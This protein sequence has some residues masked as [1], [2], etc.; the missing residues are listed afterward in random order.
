[1]KSNGRYEY[2]ALLLAA[3]AMIVIVAST[4]LRAETGTCGGVTV[5]LPFNDVMGNAFFCQIAEAYFSGLTNGT[6]ATTY[7]PSD[8]VTREQMAAFITRTLDQSLKRGSRR[9]ALNQFWVPG[10]FPAE[11]RIFIG[12]KPRMV[13]SDGADL[14]VANEFEDTVMRVRASDGK[15]L[16]TWTGAES[17]FGILVAQNRVYVTADRNPGRL[18]E[19]NPSQPAG[20]VTVVTNDLGDGTQG[21]AFDGSFIWTTAPQDGSVSKIANNGNVTTYTTGFNQPKGILYDGANI[22]VTDAG[23]HK[24]KKLNSDG[25]VAQTVSVGTSPRFPIFDGTNIWVPSFIN[26]IKVVRA[27]TGTVLATLTGNGL[28]A[29][30]SAAFDGERILVVNFAGDSVSLWRASDLTP[31]GTVNTGFATEPWGA[32]SDGINF[33]ITLSATDRLVRF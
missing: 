22:W 29:P 27:S 21:I 31:L 32:C 11:A 6:S 15:V 25:T 9:A 17:A 26:N 20:D 16:E 12:D 10:S 30:N 24:L 28:N 14:W 1:M 18:Y 4:R 2:R 3:M 7:S 5:T 13:Q 33:W 23:D 19:I 8:N